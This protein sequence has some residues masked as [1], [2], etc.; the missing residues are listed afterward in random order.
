M[1]E[2]VA[3]LLQI[4]IWFLVGFMIIAN[5]FSLGN[6]LSDFGLVL[7]ITALIA[8]IVGVFIYINQIDKLQKQEAW[9][10]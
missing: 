2:N 5:L 4:P 7:F 8:S 9:R 10:E 1:K 3:L 6:P